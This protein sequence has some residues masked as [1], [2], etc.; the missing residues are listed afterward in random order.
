MAVAAST[1]DAPASSGVVGTRSL[2]TT[3]EVA[4]ASTW[5]LPATETGGFFGA[6]QPSGDNVAIPL[7]TQLATA[8]PQGGAQSGDALARPW[9]L[10]TIGGIL[11]AIIITMLVRTVHYGKNSKN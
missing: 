6:G 5:S 1:D 3:D 10:Y 8:Q 2:D 4:L 7:F 9:I 11:V